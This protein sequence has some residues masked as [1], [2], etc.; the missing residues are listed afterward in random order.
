M[1][2]RK[3]A[4]TPKQ[5]RLLSAAKRAGER[6][7]GAPCYVFSDDRSTALSLIRRGY[8]AI[9]GADDGSRPPQRVFITD[10]GVAAIGGEG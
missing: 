1:T 8:L 6:W 3:R 7:R 4:L 10:E 5:T 9:Y 2:E